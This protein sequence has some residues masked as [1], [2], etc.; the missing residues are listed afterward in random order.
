MWVYFIILDLS[1][2]Y[3]NFLI[4]LSSVLQMLSINS[5]KSGLFDYTC[6]KACELLLWILADKIIFLDICVLKICANADFY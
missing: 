3:T 5:D 6:Q 4:I 1:T 2:Q